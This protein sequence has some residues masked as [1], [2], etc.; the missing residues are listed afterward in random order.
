MQSLTCKYKEYEKKLN[1]FPY[2]VAFQST[3]GTHNIKPQFSRPLKRH[4]RAM[5]LI[6]TWLHKIGSTK[7][8]ITYSQDSTTLMNY[9]SNKS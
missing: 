7:Y 8:E 5:M 4:S 6:V 1:H 9:L 2:L 3:L